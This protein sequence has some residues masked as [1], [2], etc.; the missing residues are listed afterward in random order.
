MI[1]GLLE[2]NYCMGLLEDNYWISIGI[3]HDKYPLVI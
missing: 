3:D 2:D 1:M